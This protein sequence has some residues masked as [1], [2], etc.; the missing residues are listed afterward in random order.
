MAEEMYEAESRGVR[1][2]TGLLPLPVEIVSRPA[3]LG[4]A[5]REM[6]GSDT[7][8]LDTESNS[9]HH[10]PEQLCLIQIASRDKVY[11]LDTISLNDLAPLQDVLADASIKK[12]VHAAEYDIRSLD[13]HCGIHIHNLFDTSIA[14]RFIGITQFG[15]AA[16]TREL[17]GITIN[18][19]KRLQRADWGQRPLSA[20]ALAY[21][22]SDVRHLLALREILEKRL[23][24]LGREAWVAEECAKIED[25]RYTARNLETAYL[26]VKGA[27][28]LDGRGL[29][30]LQSLFL[31]R[32]EEAIRQH[33]P[34]FFVLSDA[35]IIFLAT[36]PETA[37]S[38]VPGL[39]QTGL[40][41]FG[42]GLRQALRKGIT[43]PPVH[44]PRISK[45]VRPSEA[46]VQRLSCLKEL[47]TSLGFDLSLDP[48]LLWPLTSLERLAKAPETLDDELT[49]DS[50]RHWQRRVFDSLLRACLSQFGKSR[51]GA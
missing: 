26:C 50:I 19:S 33:R 27:K 41:R 48:S 46:Q 14:A 7:I 17:L 8:A 13:R 3:Q 21:A 9:F 40:K 20:E 43:A 37:L 5:I 31:F 35:T 12:V 47:R 34:P 18:K 45:A 42:Q 30:V 23:R 28:N 16:V 4:V 1:L 24:T 10:Y 2:L 15:L 25:I 6:E 29:A 32:E 22:T 36:N 49:S 38:E 51:L 44:R 39:G 11:I